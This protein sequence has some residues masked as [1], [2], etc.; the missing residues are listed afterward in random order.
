ML[1][2]KLHQKKKY[3]FSIY[4]LVFIL[5]TAADGL[6]L[7]YLLRDLQFCKTKI[8]SLSHFLIKHEN[9]EHDSLFTPCDLNKEQSNRNSEGLLSKRKS[10]RHTD[11]LLNK[12]CD[13][14]RR[15]FRQG[16][17]RY[18]HTW[19]LLSKLY[20]Q[21]LRRCLLN[22]WS[23]IICTAFLGPV[24]YRPR[25]RQAAGRVAAPFLAACDKPALAGSIVIPSAWRRMCFISSK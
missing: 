12:G 2:L 24:W 11:V 18:R 8:C 16:T 17:V 9:Y 6:C 20:Q 22:E 4:F 13:T 15:I 3:Y 14:G 21:E 1:H 25:Q 7:C 5:R 19:T 23:D 10:K